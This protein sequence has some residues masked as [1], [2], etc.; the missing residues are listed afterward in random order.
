MFNETIVVCYQCHATCYNCTDYQNVSCT[1]CTLGSAQNHLQ[2]I[3]NSSQAQGSCQ[4]QCSS[5]YY[6]F[7]NTTRV[8]EV[9][10]QCDASCFD[11]LSYHEKSCTNCSHNA[12]LR[13]LQPFDNSSQ[14]SGAC[15][16]ACDEGYFS[17]FNSTRFLDICIQCHSNCLECIGYASDACKNCS[18]GSAQK[19][20]QPPVNNT[21]VGSC[22]I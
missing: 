10:Y 22:Q 5:G 8:L 3:D 13:Y 14:A 6:S 4:S 11:C 15:Q 12:S 16:S 2:P 1:N 9:C 17:Y 21:F 18:E 19:Y 20:L 7:F